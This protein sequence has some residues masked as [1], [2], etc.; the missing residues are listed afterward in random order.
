MSQNPDEIRRDI[1]RTRAELSENV[2]ALSDSAKPS[3]I[4]R[5]KVDSVKEKV[6]GVKESIFGSDDPYDPYDRGRGTELKERA[7]DAVT[8]A[9]LAVQDAPYQVKSRTRGNPIAAGLIAAGVGALIGGLIPAS[10]MEKERATQLKEAAEPAIE[11]VKEMG[12]EAKEHLQ[13]VAQEAAES[14]KGTAQ[15]AGENV[16]A[17]AQVAKDEVTEQAQYS[18]ENVKSDA[19]TKVDETKTEVDDARHN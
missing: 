15:E 12:A 5:D 10:R 8:D 7:G 2:N 13:P 3:N 4:A 16:K 9:K 17:D 18:A 14:V 19:Q 6:A 1:E 11:E